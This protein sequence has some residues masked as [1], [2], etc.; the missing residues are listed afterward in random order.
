MPS[1]TVTF[2]FTDI[3]R[4]TRLWERFPEEMKIALH[5]HDAIL[6]DGFEH[7]GGLV[8][9]HR[10]EGDS[11]FVVFASAADAVKAAIEVQLRLIQTEWAT[12]EPVR[13]RMSLHTGESEL[14][15][16]D[17]F[18]PVVNRCA[19]LRAIAH[20]GQ[21]V[22][23]R[24]TKESAAGALPL[25]VSYGD[26]GLHTLKDLEGQEHVFQLEH[27]D[28]KRDF[29]PLSSLS[30]RRHNLPSQATRFIGRE[31]ELREVRHLLNDTRLLSL[32]GPGGSG[33]SRL[34]LQAAA[35]VMEAFPNGVWLVELAPIADQQLIMST[36][37][38]VLGVKEQT[39]KTMMAS[40]VT[41][42]RD[43]K[44]LLLLDNCE[45]L[46]EVCA[47]IAAE[48]L[49]KCPL[50]SIMATSREPLN[51]SGETI[52]RISS[53]ELPE[54]DSKLTV[55]QL[56]AFE[57]V[58][59]FV[60][61]ALNANRAFAISPANAEAVVQ[62]C[63]R[64]DGIPLAIEI[65]AA[66]IK[67]LSAEQIAER[68][69]DRF[70]LLTSGDRSKLPRQ[71]TLRA[72]MDWS[73]ELLVEQERLLLGR[74]SV[75]A[76]HFN[77]ETAEDV[78]SDD[79]IDSFEVLDCLTGLIDKSLVS[80]TE[81][82]GISRYRLLETIR[83]YGAEKLAQ[84][85][86]Q[87]QVQNKHFHYYLKR[88]EHFAAALRSPHMQEAQLRLWVQELDNV[89]K[90]LD[91][92]LLQSAGSSEML[93]KTGAFLYMLQAFWLRRGIANEG[94]QRIVQW[95]ELPA[96][97]QFGLIRARALITCFHL[98]T[99]F[100]TRSGMK[101]ALESLEL[102]TSVRDDYTKADALIILAQALY[103]DGRV[104]EA[105]D[106]IDQGIAL[107]QDIGEEWDVAQGLWLRSIGLLGS[108]D[109]SG[110]SSTARD[111]LDLSRR[112]KNNHDEAGALRVLAIIAM[113][114]GRLN[115]SKAHLQEAIQL[116]SD[117]G[118]VL[119]TIEG[120]AGVSILSAYSGQHEQAAR[121]GA[122]YLSL[123]KETGRNFSLFNNPLFHRKWKELQS[124]KPQEWAAGEQLMYE[125]AVME[126]KDYLNK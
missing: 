8:V 120:L 5:V 72:M 34:S 97:R 19:R 41:A 107:F 36:I 92:G 50:L 121:I 100:D 6:S 29:P 37:A 78:C 102:A 27:P 95:L 85:G 113:L 40:V 62:I 44:L 28:L 71:Q 46:V 116:T 58:Q 32:L 3:E 88:N 104:K 118:D 35:D 65:G 43:K 86:E 123:N 96:S 4:S 108:G 49:E 76:G 61:R 26:L 119:C 64:L 114:E 99:Y 94:L 47:S 111:A 83:Q 106:Y 54:A 101:Y 52:W 126:A 59:L 24:A 112:V 7:A 84:S 73:Y 39:G 117:L 42:I 53:L 16:G 1:G 125:Q 60:E 22:L 51:I 33:K 69:D 12:P 18:G 80:A 70:R 20:G 31:K 74:L 38:E 45:H 2:L 79:R 82:E 110:A 105:I 21:I 77:L 56:M 75:F 124:T 15:D 103:F 98:S 89:R 66:R 57:S 13:V 122:A 10:G 93:E 109:L 90:A 115:D 17:Y 11:F 63:R 91:W 25:A 87:A 81:Q 68:L 23:S 9:K 48:L 30:V 55:E 67:A 14:R